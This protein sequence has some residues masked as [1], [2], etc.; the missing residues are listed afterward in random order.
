MLGFFDG[1]KLIVLDHAFQKKTQKIPKRDI[2][3][4][5]ARKKDYF[6]RKTE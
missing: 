1:R 2:Q 5:E 3:T 6:R 4:A